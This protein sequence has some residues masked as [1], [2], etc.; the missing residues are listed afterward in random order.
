MVYILKYDFRIISFFKHELRYNRLMN[1]NLIDKI[2]H[3]YDSV[4]YE[5]F[6]VKP[7]SIFSLPNNISLSMFNDPQRNV[8]WVESNEFPDF[9]ASA[10]TE[11]DLIKE[12]HQTLLLYFDIPRYY[13]KKFDDQGILTLDDG[14]QVIL[15]P[16]FTYQVK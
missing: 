16:K 4:K 10:N 12:I 11:E 3:V 9:V 8:F 15:A 5:I 1:N 13:A 2:L 7:K 6:K 14:R